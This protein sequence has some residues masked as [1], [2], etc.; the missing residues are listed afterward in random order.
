MSN[1][2]VDH[3]KSHNLEEIIALG[4]YRHKKK[5]MMKIIDKINEMH[6]GKNLSIEE[7]RKS[8]SKIDG[9]MSDYIIS[10]RE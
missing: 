1:I 8:L 4:M 6:C 9:S 2:D 7:V 3:Q 5:K 10:E